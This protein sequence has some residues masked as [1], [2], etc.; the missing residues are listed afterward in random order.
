MLDHNLEYLTVQALKRGSRRSAR[1][2]TSIDTSA[3]AS[4]S[5]RQVDNFPPL[6]VNTTAI[7]LLP[8]YSQGGNAPWLS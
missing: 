2:A 1:R 5:V 3:W 7:V 6:V 8:P 4:K